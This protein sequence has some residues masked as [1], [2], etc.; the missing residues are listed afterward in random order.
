M[1]PG[2]NQDSYVRIIKWACL[3]I[4]L[5]LFMIGVNTLHQAQLQKLTASSALIKQKSLLISQMHDE[6]LLISRV[7]LQ[8]FQ[9]SNDQE[10]R[11]RLR[12]LSE[13]VSDHL[14]HYHQLKNITDASDIKLLDQFRADFEQW[15]HFNK[16][17]SAY[18]NVITDPGFINTLNKVDMALSQLDSNSDERRLLITQIKQDNNHSKGLS[19]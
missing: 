8:I 2:T 7:Q 16:N 5:T 1:E 12:H 15:L 13:L 17:L 4:F 11:E 10:V 14:V 9:A 18:A 6:M 19:N 3:F